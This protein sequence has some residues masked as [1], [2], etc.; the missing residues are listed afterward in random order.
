LRALQGI[1]CGVHDKLPFVIFV[2]EVHGIEPNGDILLTD[3]E[4]APNANNYCCGLP[5]MIEQH[6]LEYSGL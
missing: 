2:F 6:I 5:L 1:L 3:A 4:K